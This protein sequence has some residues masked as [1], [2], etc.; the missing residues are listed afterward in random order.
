E[1]YIVAHTGTRR[2]ST[3]LGLYYFG[4]IEG[5]GVL[6]P[7]VGFLID[8][9]SFATAFAASGMALL[10][11]AVVCSLILFRHSRSATAAGV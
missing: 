8:R 7:I 11:I 3:I 1:A 4:G 6:A 2:R 10:C 9:F 5:S